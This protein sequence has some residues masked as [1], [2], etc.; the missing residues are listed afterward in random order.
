[1]ATSTK[2]SYPSRVRSW[3][4]PGRT[5]VWGLRRRRSQPGKHLC[6]DAKNPEVYIVRKRK[7]DAMWL[8]SNY[9]IT[10]KLTWKNPPRQNHT[11]RTY[12]YYK[13]KVWIKREIHLGVLCIFLVLIGIMHYSRCHSISLMEELI[14]TAFRG[15]KHLPSW[16]RREEVRYWRVLKFTLTTRDLG[17]CLTI[18]STASSSNQFAKISKATL[19]KINSRV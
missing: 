15:S 5:S 12:L 10:G 2:T 19:G 9:P 17:L 11:Y 6:M 4:A 8:L 16:P 14:T 3:N 7:G 13:G 1:M 18:M